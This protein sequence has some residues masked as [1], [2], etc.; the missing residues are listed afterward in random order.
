MFRA[1]N[2]SVEVIVSSFRGTPLQTRQE[3][4]D[5]TGLSRVTISQ[6]V[7][8]L[9]AEGILTESDQ[10]ASNGGRKATS[11]SLNPLGGYIGIA[12]FSASGITIAVSNL[13]G[14]LISTQYKE[15]DISDGPTKSL[16]LAIE[17]LTEQFKKVPKGKRLGIIVGVPGPVN[18]ESGQVVSP[19]IMKGWDGIN[20]SQ[21]FADDFKI[22]T[23]LENDVNLM[24]LAEHRLVYP[25]IQNL[26]LVKISTGIGSGLIINGALH[27][28]A[29]GSAG[30]I[31][32]VQLDSL[33]DS[34]CRCGHDACVESFAGGWALV[35][36][37]QAMGYKVK[38]LQDIVD[39]ARN[40][41][42][43]ILRLISEASGHVGHAIAD[44][45][46]L[47]NPS[48]IVIEGRLTD[49]GDGILA[50][51]KEV[52]YQRAAALATKNLEIVPSKLGSNRGVLGAAQ[53]GLDKFFFAS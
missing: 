37:A 41:D 28:G 43:K 12:Y 22:P 27:R 7:Q 38:Y 5:K 2:R 17:W 33:K 4:Q 23:Y 24:A 34:H 16:P 21:R 45:V 36:K 49:S 53:L 15:I 18:H 46:N 1:I 32:H 35:E 31:G 50:T 40:G 48:K 13:L 42:A 39:I 25:E 10:A 19:P 9:I 44:A 47:I 52:V 51:I 11:L 8:S 6:N 30:D 26:L 20:I 14:E 3:I 29:E